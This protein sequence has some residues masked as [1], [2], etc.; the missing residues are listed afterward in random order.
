MGLRLVQVDFGRLHACQADAT[1][2]LWLS[3][4][5]YGKL[6]WLWNDR[7]PHSELLSMSGSHDLERETLPRRATYSTLL[8]YVEQCFVA[9]IKLMFCRCV[10]SQLIR[11]VQ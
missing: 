11:A 3:T 1:P 4:C 7:S 6:T 10:A 2:V 9:A 5:S 8:N